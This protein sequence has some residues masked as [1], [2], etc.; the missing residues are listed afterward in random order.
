MTYGNAEIGSATFRIAYDGSELTDGLRVADSQLRSFG[1]SMQ[2]LGIGMLGLVGVSAKLAIDQ[3]KAFVGVTKTVDGTI[4]QY[5]KLRSELFDL[6]TVYGSSF[7]EVAKLAERAGTLGIEVDKIASAT[8]T[9]LKLAIAVPDA[10]PLE[11]FTQMARFTQ[12]LDGSVDKLEAYSSSLVALGNNFNTTESEIS[13]LAIRMAPVANVIGLTATETLGIAAAMKVAGFRT[14]MAA[15]SFRRLNQFLIE[16]LTNTSKLSKELSK[17]SGL[18]VSELFDIFTATDAGGIEKLAAGLNTSIEDAENQ[19]KEA[20]TGSQSSTTDLSHIFGHPTSLTVN[21]PLN[22]EAMIALSDIMG[23]PAKDVQ[24][25]LE[26]DYVSFLTTFFQGVNEFINTNGAVAF[27]QLMEALGI[28]GVRATDL[29]TGMATQ[30]NTLRD[31]VLTAEA[32]DS[33]W[34]QWMSKQAEDADMTAE[35]FKNKYGVDIGAMIQTVEKD[36]NDKKVPVDRAMESLQR[37][38]KNRFISMGVDMNNEFINET[39]SDLLAVIQH[40]ITDGKAIDIEAGKQLETTNTTIKTATARIKESLGLLGEAFLPVIETGLNEDSPVIKFFEVLG[41]WAENNPGLAQF[42]MTIVAALGAFAVVSGTLFI[43]AP[44]WNA[45]IAVLAS[46]KAG[47]LFIGAGAVSAG[48]ALI[49]IIGV[50]VAV[51]AAMYIFRDNIWK[52]MLWITNKIDEFFS[53]TLGDLFA[54][55]ARNLK[56][57]AEKLFVPDFITD[58]IFGTDMKLEFKEAEN[59]RLFEERVGVRDQVMKSFEEEGDPLDFKNLPGLPKILGESILD[60]LKETPFITTIKEG[61]TGYELGEIGGVPNPYNISP[62]ITMEDMNLLTSNINSLVEDRNT[63]TG[64]LVPELVNAIDE[65]RNKE[66]SLNVNIEGNLIHETQL[67][68]TIREALQE[69]GRRGYIS[70]DGLSFQE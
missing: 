23:M 21:T 45:F 34:D 48:A 30:V 36:I 1:R 66:L 54:K 7:E 63:F 37:L 47:L 52:V 42:F 50:T 16:A 12:L 55:G 41:K 4:E 18:E 40:W 28:E 65:L 35:D 10:I 60:L 26:G 11:I 70:S 46:I 19:L 39:H 31:T 59:R 6:T 2:A 17:K 22:S 5:D 27:D 64:E 3:E 8:E 58:K 25:L 51:I 38:L 9:A 68:D 43:M 15:S 61:G 33:V 57:L 14:E 13:G 44:G 69:S 32:E 29:T 53:I 56:S 20:F 24:V 49:G 67:Q 62:P